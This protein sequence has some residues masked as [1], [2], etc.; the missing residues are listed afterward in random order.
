MDSDEAQRIIAGGANGRLSR[1]TVRA[2]RND[3]GPS[4]DDFLPLETGPN[5]T[6]FNSQPWN[7][8]DRLRTG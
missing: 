2:R 8:A 5:L 3:A 6:P 7:I 4:F 1:R